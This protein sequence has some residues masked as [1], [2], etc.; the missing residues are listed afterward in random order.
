MYVH[1]IYEY[2]YIYI[3]MYI[4]IYIYSSCLLKICNMLFSGFSD[5]PYRNFVLHLFFNK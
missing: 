5:A 2:I 3:Y 1:I 4:Y